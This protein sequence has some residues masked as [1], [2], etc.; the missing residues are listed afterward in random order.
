MTQLLYVY[1]HAYPLAT[2]KMQMIPVYK[3]KIVC[4]V[5][6]VGYDPMDFERLY[7]AKRLAHLTTLM[8]HLMEK[9]TVMM[10]AHSMD[11]SMT[12]PVAQPMEKPMATMMAQLTDHPMANPMVHPI[13]HLITTIKI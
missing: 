11:Q 6:S 5:V 8:V 9:Q 3:I 4:N 12:N 13:T 10:I 1:N 2:W 7:S